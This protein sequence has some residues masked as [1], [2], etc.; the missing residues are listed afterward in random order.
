[1]LRKVTRYRG[2]INAN[3]LPLLEWDIAR[4]HSRKTRSRAARLLQREYGL[5][6]SHAALVAELAGLPVEDE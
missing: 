4:Q 5:S 3:E 6:A 1:M 2:G